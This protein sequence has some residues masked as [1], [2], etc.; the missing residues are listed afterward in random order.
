VASKG[1]QVSLGPD[2]SIVIARKEKQNFKSK[3]FLGSNRVLDRAYEII[4]KNNKTIAVDLIIEDRIPISQ[5]KEIK[6]EDLEFGDGQYNEQTGIIRWEV[7]LAPQGT[8]QKNFSFTVKH[9]KQ[10]R[11]NL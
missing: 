9:P 7:Q 11:I 4:V 5:N 1:I 6:V 10:Q 2:T 3:S 8:G